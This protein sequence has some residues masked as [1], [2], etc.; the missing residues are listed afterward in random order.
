MQTTLPFSGKAMDRL[1]AMALLVAA[2]DAGSQSAA[3]RKLR[4][5]PATM[6]RKFSDRESRLG[7]RLLVRSARR[8]ALTDAGRACVA[9]ASASSRK[10]RRR[11]APRSPDDLR[12]HDCITFE[13]IA[14]GEEWKFVADRVES[15][16]PAHSRLAVNTAG[17]AIDA[18]IA[19]AGITRALSYQVADQ[20]R[21]GTLVLVLQE[22]E[23]PAWPVSLVYAGE[24]YLPL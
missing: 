23:P 22:F 18:A 8:L 1:E 24:R 14:S 17:A 6:S 5:P 3:A 7:A 12:E 9:R 21:L 2:V 20:L 13:A 19:G 16:I 10:S 15:V 4:I 11:S